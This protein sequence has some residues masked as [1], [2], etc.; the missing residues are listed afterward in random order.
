MVRKPGPH[1]LSKFFG[2][3]P[4]PPPP[5]PILGVNHMPWLVIKYLKTNKFHYNLIN[6]RKNTHKRHPMAP[7]AM[8]CLLWVQSVNTLGPRQIGCHFPDNIFKCIFFNENVWI[9]IKISLKCVPKGPVNSIPALV[10]IMAWHWP[11]NKP[12]SATMM[13]RLLTH[14]CVTR[15]P[16]SWHCKAILCSVLLKF[17]YALKVWSILCLCNDYTKCNTLCSDIYEHYVQRSCYS[18]HHRLSPSHRECYSDFDFVEGVVV[19]PVRWLT[20]C[21]QGARIP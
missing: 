3:P 18:S 19:Q 17:N 10:Q 15:P 6:F 20:Y 1:P 21:L 5:P 2:V 12:L 4:P 13:V 7:W 9:S 8:G 16:V 11:G 14:I